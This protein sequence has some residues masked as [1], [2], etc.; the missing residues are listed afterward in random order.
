MASGL[1]PLLPVYAVRLGAS[2]ALAG[3][4]LAV[5]YC[6]LA[7]AAVV[8]GSVR[9]IH[10]QRRLFA[11]AGAANV[12]ALIL[13]GFFAQLWQLFILT[14]VIWY[15]GGTMLTISNVMTGLLAKEAHRGRTFGLMYLAAPLGAIIGG[16]ALGRLADALG[17]MGM[18]RV[19]AAWAILAPVAGTLALRG[20]TAHTADATDTYTTSRQPGVDTGILRRLL[21]LLG[22]TLLVGIATYTG[23]LSMSLT[24]EMQAFSATAVSSTATIGGLIAAPL[25][26][27]AGRISDRTGRYL[28]LALAYTATIGGL[29][30]LSHA[31][32]L[33]QFWLAVAAFEIA[34]RA[35]ISI[36]SALTTD[37]VPPPT[38]N[39]AISLLMAMSSIA[40]IV[41]FA[42]AGVL[43]QTVG[44]PQ[45]QYVAAAVALGA[46]GLLVL[47][48]RRDAPVRA[49]TAES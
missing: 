3:A 17:F 31:N 40:G 5:A 46:I 15:F 29:L 13:L 49:V 37:L 9:G 12:A 38:L 4:Y 36:A 23:R 26:P 14:A 28:L 22:A 27:L 30:T 10:R 19:L 8:S 18:F 32:Q 43:L 25:I 11:L 41:G 1:V 7:A 44:S 21:P 48:R 2:Q 35:G 24:M 33:W 45:A 16:L 6:T 34:A 47:Q 39:R 20:A 42:A